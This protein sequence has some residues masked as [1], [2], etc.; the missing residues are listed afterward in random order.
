MK[1]VQPWVISLLLL[2][3]GLFLGPL[4]PAWGWGEDGHKLIAEVAYS[5]LTV[6]AKKNVDFLLR[7]TTLDKAAVWPDAM[8]TW[9][10]NPAKP[11]PA[12]LVGDPQA[13]LF[14]GDSRNA[15]QPNW[16]FVDLPNGSA[17]YATAPVGTGPN[18][19]VHALRRCIAVLRGHP[20]PGENLNAPQA[21]RLLIHYVGDI[22]QPLHAASGY[23]AA[24][25]SGQYHLVMGSAATEAASDRGGNN[26][27]YGPA[28]FDELHGHWDFD[29]VDKTATGAIDDFTGHLTRLQSAARAL[30]RAP[31]KAVGDPM[32]WPVHWTNESASEAA[33]AYQPFL[34]PISGSVTT[35]PATGEKTFTGSIT[36]PPDYD[37]QFKPVADRRLALAGFRLAAVLNATLSGRDLTKSM[38]GSLHH[39]THSCNVTGLSHICHIKR[40]RL[41][42]GGLRLALREPKL[43]AP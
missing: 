40:L 22:H 5:G 6:Q 31:Y 7:G 20:L 41:A 13:T 25:A 33:R 14:F 29:L 43:A 21:L 30:G 37:A 2:L 27:H 9:Q 42:G 17:N 10:R 18:D 28:K 34:P 8:R 35:D 19:I 26:L 36:L 12:P 38:G 39:R 4:R 23:W 32:A 3:P 1:R 16:H 11:E 15:G 24:E